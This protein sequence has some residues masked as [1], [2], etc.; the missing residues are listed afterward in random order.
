MTF[1][2]EAI[3]NPVLIA[4]ILSWFT[5][6]VLKVL[7][8]SVRH[9]FS[10]ERLT[11]GGGMP[12]SH[13]AT[14]TGLTVSTAIVYGSGGFEFVMALF[15]S[16]IVIYDS[17]GVRMETGKEAKILNLM[18]KRDMEEG[19]KPVYEKELQEKMGHTIPEIAA[20]IVIGA[21]CAVILC[22]LLI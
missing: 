22:N 7:L 8:D 16:I 20:G 15:F 6:Q 4:T 10:T 19:K 1:V 12:S 21:V 13:S 9:G 5:A 17:A 14:V 18:R 2:M 3:H 11:G